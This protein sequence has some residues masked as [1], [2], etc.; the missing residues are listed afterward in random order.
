MLVE[1]VKLLLKKQ[2]S[3]LAPNQ[4]NSMKDKQLVALIGV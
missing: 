1:G 2:E 4:V 3:V